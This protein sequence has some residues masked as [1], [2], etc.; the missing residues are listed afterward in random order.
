MTISRVV[1]S[2]SVVK[3]DHDND[4]VYTTVG[5]VQNATPPGRVRAMGDSTC[6]ED[7]LEQMEVGI[8]E[9]SEFAFTVI[10]EPGESTWNMLDALF[11]AKTT[12]NWQFVTVHATPR[13]QT[14]SGVVKQ[15]SPAQADS[16]TVYTAQCVVQRKGAITT[17]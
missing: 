2:G 9:A 1:A 7:T 4:T 5:C 15:L 10:W 17:T 13:T 16:K 8:E 6:F 3:V 12:R 14:F 11:T